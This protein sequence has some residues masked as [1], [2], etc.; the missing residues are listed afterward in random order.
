MA[1]ILSKRF[2]EL[3]DQASEV[4]ATEG[5]DGSEGYVNYDLLLNWTVKVKNLISNTCGIDSQHF[6]HLTQAEKK[7]SRTASVHNLR[8]MKAVLLACQEDYDGGYLTPIRNLVQ[9][10]VFD[11]ELDQASELLRSGYEA[12]AVVIAGTVLE[13]SLR[14]LCT[15]NSLPHGNLDRMNADLAKHGLYNANMAKRI[16]ALAGIRNSAAHGK[17]DEFTEADAKTMIEDIERFLAQY[18]V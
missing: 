18:L 9:A 5:E 13:T 6:M 11:S 17:P 16:T 1:N 4:E 8:A 12:A 3:V 14:E 7:S 2:K 10:E 15:R